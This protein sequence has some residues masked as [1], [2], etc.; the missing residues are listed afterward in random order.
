MW[1]YRYIMIMTCFSFFSNLCLAFEM[2]A[3]AYLEVMP[4]KNKYKS[5]VDAK[6]ETSS[7]AVLIQ[8][9]WPPLCLEKGRCTPKIV[10]LDKPK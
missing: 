1:L 7:K 2:L 4:V 8:R 9:R 10:I 3:N 5:V 6:G